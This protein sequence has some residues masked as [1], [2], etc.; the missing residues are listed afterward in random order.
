M[1]TGKLVFAQA[2]DHLPLHTFRRCV[3]RYG[4]NRYIKSFSCQEQFRCMAFAQFTYRESL[5]DIETCLNAQSSKLYHMG[6]RSSVA[7]STLADANE[8]RD[9]RIYADFAQWMHRHRAV[10]TNREYVHRSAYELG[11]HLIGYELQKVFAAVDSF[12]VSDDPDDAKIGVAGWGEGGMLDL[13]AA[14]L[15]TRIDDLVEVRSRYAIVLHPA[16]VVELHVVD[17]HFA[18]IDQVSR[19]LHAPPLV[20]RRRRQVIH[21]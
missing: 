4:G 19:Q 21:Q 1:F 7:R 5:R 13:Y 16:L 12:S 15:N 3:Q 9:W 17:A 6:I 11:R 20:S 2:M 14:D 8:K 18:I 10:L